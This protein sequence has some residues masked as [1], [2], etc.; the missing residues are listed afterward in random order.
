MDARSGLSVSY[1]VMYRI[2]NV[3]IKYCI[4]KLRKR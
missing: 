4:L 3:S 1:Y 2:A